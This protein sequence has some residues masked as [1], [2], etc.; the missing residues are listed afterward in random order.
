MRRTPFPCLLIALV[1][2]VAATTAARASET[3]REVADY[4]LD[5]LP[6]ELPPETRRVRC[7][8]S[9]LVRYRGSTVPFQSHIEVHREFLP[10]VR[11][12]EQV[13]R[14]VAIE[15][16]GRAPRVIVH[17]GAY[18]CRTIRRARGVLSEHAFGNALDVRGFDF[19]RA[20]RDE[21]LPE[22]MPASMARSFRVRVE[23][24]WKAPEG[25]RFAPH[26]AFLAALCAR[27]ERERDLF[28]VMLGPSYPGHHNH[29]HLDRAPFQFVQF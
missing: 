3:T 27:L 26:A 22:G 15:T 20:Q 9:Q 12:F 23:D 18:N 25:T 10:Y 13:V 21:A 29:L 24:H 16:F 19:W 28:R 1:G 2:L 5:A 17:H 6:R 8:T 14:E 4:P 11:R 7:D